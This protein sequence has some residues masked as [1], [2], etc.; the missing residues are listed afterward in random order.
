M[1]EQH[2][3]CRCGAIYHRTHA[4]ASRRE[5][6]SFECSVC[7]ATLEHRLGAGLSADRRCGTVE[8]DQLE[9]AG[10]HP[11]NEGSQRDRPAR[12]YALPQIAPPKRASTVSA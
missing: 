6:S 5:M 10:E 3:K 9:R 12:D 4:M 7:G 1:D 8:R 11:A 2:R